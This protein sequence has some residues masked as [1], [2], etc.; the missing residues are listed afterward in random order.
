[1]SDYNGW[2]NWETWNVALWIGNDE[3]LYL[4]AKESRNYK[5]FVA[6]LKEISEGTP[7]SFET[8][9]SPIH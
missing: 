6:N 2:E 9:E 3:G 8:P 4:L 7:I 5:N 1:M